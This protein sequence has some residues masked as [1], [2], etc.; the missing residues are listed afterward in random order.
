VDELGCV[1]VV[2]YLDAD[3][4]LFAACNSVW[5]VRF[6]EEFLKD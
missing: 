3:R 4:E 1:E 5:Q 2:E 6:A